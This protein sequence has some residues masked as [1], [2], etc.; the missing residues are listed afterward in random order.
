MMGLSAHQNA[1]IS[2][3]ILC[4]TT[5]LLPVFGIIGDRYKIKPIL[6]ASTILIMILLVPLCVFV[7]N[8]NYT[9]LFVLGFLYIFPITCI[10][11][12]LPYLLSNLFH[13]SVRFTGVSLTFNLA[14][15]IIGGF[16]PLYHYGFCYTQKIKL[17]LRFFF[18]YA[19]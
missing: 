17:L 1:F 14:D 3:L 18:F 8:K 12:Y 9:F 19:H 7:N 5:I 15:G 10:T 4:L 6:V 13:S 11:A 2:L 16:T